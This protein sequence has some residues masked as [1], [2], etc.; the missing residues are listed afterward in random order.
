MT[1]TTLGL[2]GGHSSDPASMG[3][4]LGSRSSQE[5]TATSTYT[6]HAVNPY[7]VWIYCALCQVKQV[8]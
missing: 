2:Y 1:P 5:T 7:V 8:R 4:F 6:K 3:G